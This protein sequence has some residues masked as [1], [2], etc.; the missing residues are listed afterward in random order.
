MLLSLRALGPQVDIRGFTE[1]MPL[2]SSPTRYNGKLPAGM[3]NHG[4]TCYLNAVLQVRWQ[5]EMY[6]LLHA[7]S[8][9]RT[10]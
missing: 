8:C 1:P 4:N 6:L 10:K 3:L 9:C 2:L 5:G 7:L